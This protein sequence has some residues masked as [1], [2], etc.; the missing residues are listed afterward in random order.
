MQIGVNRYLLKFLQF[1]YLLIDNLREVEWF[2]AFHTLKI[3]ACIFR[4]CSMVLRCFK[5][6]GYKHVII[7]I[8][9]M[10]ASETNGPLSPVA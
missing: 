3:E 5:A 6:L 7:V 8:I 4:L 10:M 1:H 2:P 9:S